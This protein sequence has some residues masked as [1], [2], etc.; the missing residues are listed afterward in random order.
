[1]N[2]RL[3]DFLR[4]IPLL[5]LVASVA[6][7]EEKWVADEI[8]TQIAEL[9]KTV[10]TLQTQLAKQGQELEAVKAELEKSKPTMPLTGTEKRILGKADA[11]LMIVEFTDYQCPY[12]RKHHTNTLGRLRQ[13]YV[14][15]GKVRYLVRDYPLG[16]HGEAKKAAIAARCAGEQGK[17]WP[18]HDRLFEQQDKLSAETY[19]RLAQELGLKADAFAACQQNPKQ[20]Q[21]VDEDTALG[22]QLGVQGTPAFFIG[23]VQGDKLK[24]LK[25]LSGTQAFEAF[26]KVVEGMGRK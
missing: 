12:C 20:A 22:E 15:T 9:R 6:Q 24:D 2:K 3:N 17:Y 16:F 1:M 21:A 25:I 10:Q 18:M 4:L 14:D 11:P 23:R 8:F 5:L 7:A 26:Q 19:T 13:E